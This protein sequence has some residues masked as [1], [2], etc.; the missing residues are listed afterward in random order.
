MI[1]CDRGV[2]STV[3]ILLAGDGIKS[4][5]V[6]PHRKRGNYAKKDVVE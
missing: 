6:A 1:I 3:N 4:D 5:P 2:S